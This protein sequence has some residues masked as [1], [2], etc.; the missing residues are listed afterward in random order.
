MRD[1]IVNSKSYNM[2]K[3]YCPSPK[4][5][6]LKFHPVII[7]MLTMTIIGAS[8]GTNVHA[9]CRFVQI[10]ASKDTSF[11]SLPCDFPVIDIANASQQEKDA[12]SG[13]VIKWKAA[14]P[15]Y[16]HLAFLQTSTQ[17]YF[18]ISLTD[19]ADFSSEKK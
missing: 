9:Q 11:A 7:L 15:G 13:D 4:K 16:D 8:M 17:E 2:K 1:F 3:N 12:F 14:N 5:M 19:F 10:K 6:V 18:E